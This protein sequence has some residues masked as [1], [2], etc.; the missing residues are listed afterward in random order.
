[1]RRVLGG[2]GASILFLLSCAGTR[3]EGVGSGWDPTRH[4]LVQEGS[5]LGAAPDAK[6][7]QKI[8][9]IAEGESL[10]LGAELLSHPDGGDRRL[11]GSVSLRAHQVADL[12][13]ELEPNRFRQ[14]VQL[15]ILDAKIRVYAKENGIF[16]PPSDLRLAAKRAWA[17]LQRKFRRSGL[18]DFEA[19]CWRNFGESSEIL[20]KKSRLAEARRLLR[21]YALRFRLHREGSVT[22]DFVWSRSKQLLSRFHQRIQSGASFAPLLRNLLKED[23]S[24][25]GGHLPPMP[26]EGGHRALRLIRRKKGLGAIPPQP[27]KG[28]D[29]EP[30]FAWVRILARK[31]GDSRSFAEVWPLLQKDLAR[32]PVGAGEL[33]LFLQD[34]YDGGRDG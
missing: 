1:M 24:A 28:P 27:M 32:N 15:L 30:G 26:L 7:V 3:I 19:Y 34:G 25:R 20:R 21:S 13:E 14:L 6:G 11:E 23:P 16:V 12:L 29:G 22:F 9:S 5:G 10:S 31:P 33:E 2:G 17:H 18:R 8:P 4:D